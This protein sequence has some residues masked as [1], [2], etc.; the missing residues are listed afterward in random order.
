MQTY[1]L[2]KV[3]GR[4]RRRRLL[5]VLLEV[6]LVPKSPV[7]VRRTVLFFFFFFFILVPTN[8]RFLL[9]TSCKT[10]DGGVGGEPRG[11]FKEKTTGAG[12]GRRGALPVL[13]DR[14]LIPGGD[15]LTK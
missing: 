13:V 6:H 4:G 9:R 1:V 15:L 5:F 12:R 14:R 10:N 11:D 7:L 3:I 8:Q 2:G